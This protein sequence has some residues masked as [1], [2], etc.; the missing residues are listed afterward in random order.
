MPLESPEHIKN[1]ILDIRHNRY[2]REDL[3]NLV[4]LIRKKLDQEEADKIL[5]LID[6]FHITLIEFFIRGGILVSVD[7]EII[8]VDI[9]SLVDVEESAVRLNVTEPGVTR[10]PNKIEIDTLQP[11]KISL[12]DATRKSTILNR[13][14]RN[15]LGK[16]RGK[17]SNIFLFDPTIRYK[18]LSQPV[19]T[20]LGNR[21][22]IYMRSNGYSIVNNAN[23]T[24]GTTMVWYA[25]ETYRSEV[26][27]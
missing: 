10:Y 24:I 21:F 15:Y 4:N 5:N 18:S 25:F 8:E 11:S 27:G 9:T 7:N 12:P 17:M 6:N 3:M 23:Q 22:E 1:V 19:E 14:L 13:A 2:I 26:E 20:I 16:R